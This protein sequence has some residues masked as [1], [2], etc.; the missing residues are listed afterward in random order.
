VIRAR[1]AVSA[2]AA[3]AFLAACGRTEAPLERSDPPA[4][5]HWLGRTPSAHGQLLWR[6]PID[7]RT[8]QPGV[9]L[10]E[11]SIRV[12]AG[13]SSFTYDKTGHAVHRFVEDSYYLVSSPV[14]DRDG[15]LYFASFYATSLDRQ[16]RLR[17]RVPLRD[18][19]RATE[20]NPF[21]LSDDGIVYSAQN[22]G[23]LKALDASNG[24]LLWQREL[25][26]GPTS[27]ATYPLGGAGDELFVVVDG[28][29]LEVF[30]RRTGERR[31]SMPAPDPAE[32]DP[33]RVPVAIV[34][35]GG[36][37]TIARARDEPARVE[38]SRFGADGSL[39]W[40]SAQDR[41]RFPLAIDARQRV[42]LLEKE[43]GGPSSSSLLVAHDPCRG[44]P[45]SPPIRLGTLPPLSAEILGADGTLYLFHSLRSGTEREL[46]L[47]AVDPRAGVHRLSFPGLLLNG[48]E[49]RGTPALD[50]DGVLYFVAESMTGAGEL[51]AVQTESH[52]LAGTSLP[53]RR[54]D[55][56][57]TGWARAMAES[58]VSCP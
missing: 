58:I 33:R 36:A 53:S 56:R 10:S 41:F 44:E 2:F 17:W 12:N 14:A 47:V 52:G 40:A 24:D 38:V 16:G 6:A 7:S 23:L 19:A 4:R 27:A 13:S 50:D 49:W 51:V 1:A 31:R 34:S 25:A 37:L 20:P 46:V 55:N 15:N 42:L 9:V 43:P 35:G 45:L 21:V 22:D 32:D 57:Q 8:P 30:D 3:L 11:D 48:V 29:S 5:E 54:H 28:A 18:A 39:W 26:P